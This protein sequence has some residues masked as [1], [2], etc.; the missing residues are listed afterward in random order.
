VEVYQTEEQQV[1]AI[2]G[3]WKENGSAIIAGLV[4]GF[5]AFIGFNVYKD[6]QFEQEL[7]VS[8]SFQSV[9]EQADADGAVY[10]T[11]GDKFIA[12]NGESSYAS[13]TALALAKNAATHKDWT[14]AEKYLISAINTAKDEGVKAI[15]TLRL[16]RVQLQLTQADKALATINTPLPASFKAAVEEI[17]GDAYLLQDKK[18]LARSAYQA[19][20][21][22][23]GQAGNQ[24]LKMKLNDLTQ[25]VDLSSP[26]TTPVNK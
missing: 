9:I 10:K 12:E 14:E 19:A 22:I 18:D 11:A 17:K 23:E 4:I 2:K 16:A 8:E 1:E 26:L 25:V 15:A 3:Y 13:L 5:S 24:V 20:S 7:A 6:N 21:D